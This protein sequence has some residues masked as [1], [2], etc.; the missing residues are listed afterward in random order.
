[1][2]TDS[3]YGSCME[4]TATA[5]S[6][7]GLP[8]HLYQFDYRSSN[9]MLELLLRLQRENGVSVQHNLQSEPNSMPAP[10]SLQVSLP[11]LICHGDELFSLFQLKI[12]GLRPPTQLDRLVSA[13]LTSLWS[14]FAALN[15][16][17]WLFKAGGLWPTFQPKRNY[18]LLQQS[19]RVMQYPPQSQW[20]F[21]QQLRA[22]LLKTDTYLNINPQSRN[23]AQ[24]IP[25]HQQ[26]LEKTVEELTS[27]HVSKYATLAFAMIG[28]SI[29]LLLLVFLLL[30][31]LWYTKRS[32]SFCANVADGSNSP[33][34]Y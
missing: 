3:M 15:N 6:S 30:A 20:I 21:W 24:P 25:Q 31:I 13:Q 9:S 2:A 28:V 16:H 29:G 12:S 27:S 14:E 11:K 1:M 19:P 22:K 17:S 26:M 18:L 8:V 23:Q 5:L 10:A 34:L 32:Q 7:A 33:S 4:Q